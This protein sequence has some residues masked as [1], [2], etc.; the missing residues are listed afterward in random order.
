MA[1]EIAAQPVSRH[2]RAAGEVRL[3][4]LWIVAIGLLLVSLGY[5]YFTLHSHV[6]GAADRVQRLEGQL[7]AEQSR[8]DQLRMEIAELRSLDRLLPLA[9]SRLGM[10]AAAP[11][12]L[13]FVPVPSFVAASSLPGAGVGPARAEGAAASGQVASAGSALSRVRATAVAQER[14]WWERIVG[15]ISPNASAKEY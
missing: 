14:G 8:T 10:R 3:P 13:T 5:A 2:Y 4:W 7:R 1:M 12:E 6:A 11:S 15:I 9:E